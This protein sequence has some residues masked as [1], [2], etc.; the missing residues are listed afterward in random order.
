MKQ[1]F[2][3]GLVGSL[4]IVA[5]VVGGSTVTAC[6][7]ES[8]PTVGPVE[9]EGGPG[10]NNDSSGGDGGDPF[11]GCAKSS[12]KAEKLP[13]DMVIGLDTSFSMDFDSKWANV[14]DAMKAFVG[15][16]A[17]AD[18]GIA[19][20]FFP[21][22]KQ[23][24]VADY[25]LPAVA[26]GLQPLVR[27]AITTSLDAQQ[28]F[29]GT[30]IVPLLEGLTKYLQTNA[31]P[32]RKQVIV[33]ATD[34]V[35]DDT[36]LAETATS[37]A[38]TIANAV[39]VADKALKGTPSIP[40]FVIGVGSELSALNAIGQAGGTGNAIL[41]DTAANAQAAFLKALDSIRRAAIPCDYE[42]PASG[43][44]SAA[45][46]NVTY[47]PS[48]GPAQTYAFVGNEAGCVKA[49][50]D[51]WYF[52]NEMNPTRVIL[53]K[54]ACDIVKLDDGG[55]VGVVFGCPRIVR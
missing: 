24:S 26:L 36:C 12:K 47:T 3:F 14:R 45:D 37:K 20:Q 50:N 27:S 11:A 46:T 55:S 48:T 23:C 10:F 54:G 21:L 7:S 42:L 41:V 34:G 35:P 52:D 43:G 28:M 53:C 29:G 22:R 33:L 8:E 30:P 9:F 2:R 19:L 15:N 1:T 5:V 32:A 31:N 16:P 17:Y 18:L 25:T 13:V 6:G 39:V 49:P 4:A 40:T 38:N 51:G 44:V